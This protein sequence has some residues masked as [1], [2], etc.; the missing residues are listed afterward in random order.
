MID[1]DIFLANLINEFD[2]FDKKNSRMDYKFKEDENWDSLLA[3]SFI[4]VLD[5]EFSVN[6]SGDDL[7][8]CDTFLDLYNLVNEKK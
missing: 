8:N 6:I 5:K 7:V 4:S 2:D 3:L 1:K